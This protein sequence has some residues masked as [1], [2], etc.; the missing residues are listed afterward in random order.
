MSAL[1]LL[2]DLQC[3]GRDD[4]EALG[5]DKAQLDHLWECLSGAH[6]LKVM[7][8]EDGQWTSTGG[9]TRNVPE[10]SQQARPPPPPPP[11]PPAARLSGRLLAPRSRALARPAQACALLPS[12]SRQDGARMVGSPAYRCV[13]PRRRRH[14]LLHARRR[15]HAQ[16]RVP[17][18]SSARQVTLTE[19]FASAFNG[20]GRE[21]NALSVTE[22]K[23]TDR[24]PSLKKGKKGKRDKS[25]K[26]ETI[27]GT[28]REKGAAP[29]PAMSKGKS[30][31]SV[32][33]S[34]TNIFGLGEVETPSTLKPKAEAGDASAAIKALE[35]EPD[36]AEV[37]RWG[38][39]ALANAAEES[40]AAC[41]KVTEVGGAAAAVKALKAL[42]GARAVEMQAM[43]LLANLSSGEEAS[44]MAVVAAGGPAEAVRL[45]DELARQ[46]EKTVR[47]VVQQALRTV[48]NLAC[49]TVAVKTAA[50]DA[51]AAPAVRKAMDAL[52]KDA[53]TQRFGCAAFANMAGGEALEVGRGAMRD[54]GGAACVVKAMRANPLHTRILAQGCRALASLA[55]GDEACAEAVRA[56]S[57][58]WE[59]AVLETGGAPTV[60]A[61]LAAFPRVAEIVGWSVRTL[62]FVANVDPESVRTC[63]GVCAVVKAMQTHPADAVVLA[64]ALATLSAMLNADASTVAGE[65][66]Q[67]AVVDAGT[68]GEVC[69]V[70]KNFADVVELNELGAAAWPK[71][72]PWQR[73]G[74]PPAAPQTPAA[75]CR[76]L[77]M[78]RRS[79]RVH[80]TCFEGSACGHD[81]RPESP[82]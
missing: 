62:G 26:L 38:C 5:L 73:H 8:T 80:A 64:E 75:P 10:R 42:P 17:V 71:W 45:L 32:L 22:M 43:R 19:R 55:A 47:L 24:I 15:L 39:R 54:A 72:P 57:A 68:A 29:A 12:S 33:V 40:A 60:A 78:P 58:A 6:P 48:A 41:A 70:F 9:P 34:F 50:L 53:Q 30:R 51:G 61:A 21:A 66:A 25:Q 2:D 82:T 1:Q 79:H 31:P 76:L 23:P 65:R 81:A 49:G 13:G 11:P 28:P 37:Q 69:K 77:F 16:S 27:E 74:S 46:G 56:G 3:L 63:G 7:R 35:L 36:G 44:Q 4:L 59:E 14:L 18:P 20:K 52:P 67:T